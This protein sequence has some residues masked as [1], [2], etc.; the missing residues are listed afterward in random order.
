MS[1]PSAVAKARQLLE[2]GKRS[3]AKELLLTQGY[4]KRLDP[5]IIEAYPT[6]IPAQGVLLEKLNGVIAQLNAP[7]AA[8]KIEAAESIGKAARAETGIVSTEWLADPRTTGPLIELL[9]DPDPAVVESAAQTLGNILFRH[10]RDLRAFDPL[11]R[12]LEHPNKAIRRSA[13]HGIGLLNH[14]DRW[15]LLLPRLTDKSVDVRRA[16]CQRF[17]VESGA[18][19]VPASMQKLAVPIIKGLLADSNADVRGVAK[20]ALSH[21]GG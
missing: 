5:E 11:A 3:E 9:A 19:N 6:L 15:K 8:A 20:S 13:A 4:V 2:A 12:L 21:M 1:S 17:S 16:A 7:D 18:G 10:F 14:K